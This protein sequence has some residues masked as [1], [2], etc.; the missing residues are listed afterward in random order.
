M[1]VDTDVLIWY[2]RG[3]E[4]AAR[5]LEGLPILRLSAVTYMELVQGC[6]NRQELERLKK[7]L[8]RRQ[9][10]I[11]PISEAISERAMALVE[12]HFLGD[13]LLLADALIA[14]TAIEHSLALSS[15]NSKHFRQIQGLV[16]QQFQP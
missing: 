5:F 8:N 4:E 14:A 10:V 15:A 9:A 12:A 3:H 16:L 11:L 13:G 6:R 7:D 2:L 1:L